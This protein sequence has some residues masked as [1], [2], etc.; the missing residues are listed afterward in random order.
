MNKEISIIIATYNAENTIKRCIDSIV[1]QKSDEI[2]LIIIDGDSKDGTV[3]VLKSYGSAIDMVVSEPD[4]GLYDAWNKALQLVTG[5]WI[6]FLGA[7]DYL[8]PDAMSFYLN[9]LHEKENVDAF[10]LI[11]AQCLFVNE[12]GKVLK[13]W[14]HPYQW[15]RF[16]DRMEISHGS[17]LHNYKLFQELGKFN[18]RFRISA[19]YEF[20]LRKKMNALFFEQKILVMQIGG[21]SDSIKGAWETYH[22]KRCHHYTCWCKDFYYLIRSIGGYWK[23]RLW[24]WAKCNMNKNE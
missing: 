15:E 2:E 13:T 3:N 21:M 5:K 8:F 17:T 16:V 22:V 10:D 14:G 6:M 18:I 7:D 23:R 12:K 11:C 9:F 20:L 24:Y 19:D 1:C 4:K